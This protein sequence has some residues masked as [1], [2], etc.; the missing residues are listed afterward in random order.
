MGRLICNLKL[1][2]WN[3]YFPLQT[4]GLRFQVNLPEYI[5]N[6]ALR[7]CWGLSQGIGSMGLEISSL[8]TFLPMSCMAKTPDSAWQNATHEHSWAIFTTKGKW[9]TW[10]SGRVRNSKENQHLHIPLFPIVVFLSSHEF[11]TCLVF[12]WASFRGH[13]HRGHS[14]WLAMQGSVNTRARTSAQRS[15]SQVCEI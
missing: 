7:L 11:T 8:L 13:R 1:D 5:Y 3:N 15:S 14:P 10:A 4:R 12:T 6:F 9:F 2:L